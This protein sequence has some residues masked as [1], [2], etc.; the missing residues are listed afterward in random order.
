MRKLGAR[1]GVDRLDRTGS[2]RQAFSQRETGSVY[3]SGRQRE[4]CLA[5]V[6]TSP[7]KRVVGSVFGGLTK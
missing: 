3:V 6:L 5:E 7:I 1:I 2:G 4:G